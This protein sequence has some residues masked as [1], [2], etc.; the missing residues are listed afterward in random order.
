VTE[1][2]L[3]AQGF[4]RTLAERLQRGAAFFLDYG[5]PDAEYYHPQRHGGTLMC[6][7]G[8]QADTDPLADVGEKDISAHL[9]FS[10]LALAGQ[11][12][13]LDVAGYTSQA[14]F[15]LNCG[16]ADLMQAVAVPA[17]SAAHRLM[18]EHEMGELFKVLAFARGLPA[19]WQPLGFLRGDR[20]HRL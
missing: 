16:L 20:S 14:H 17:R 9:D 10:A 6:H 8:H 12:A 11:D 18:A 7:R 15:L 5:F 4:V 19:G 13:G 2:H 3:Q 1:L